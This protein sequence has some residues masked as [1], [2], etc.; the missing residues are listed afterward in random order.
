MYAKCYC[1]EYLDE[2][3]CTHVYVGSEIL[4]NTERKVFIHISTH[5]IQPCI[6]SD[7]YT[8]SGCIYTQKCIY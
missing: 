2:C 3:A 5:V 4:T 1:G 8:Q 7:K 6:T